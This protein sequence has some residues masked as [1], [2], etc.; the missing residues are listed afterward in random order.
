MTNHVLLDNVSHKDL[1]VNKIYRPGGPYDVNVARVFPVEFRQVQ[2]DYPLFFVK[3]KESGHFETVAL[4]GF[5]QGENLFLDKNGWDAAHIPLSIQRQPL[6]I[7]FQEQV[8]DGVPRRVPV[9]HIDL[10]HP[11]VSETEGEPLFLPHGGESPWL[12]QMSSVLHAIQQG[13]ETSQ[14][15]SELLVGL[16]LIESLTVKVEFVD[17]SKHSLTGL[18]TINEDK[19]AGLGAKALE[20]LHQKGHLFDVY[21]LLASLPNVGELIKR[22][23]RTLAG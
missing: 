23:N 22:K 9:V 3:N 5:D 14:S 15:F 20:V 19:L 4:L 10:D 18:Y 7:G 12:E 8:D 11:E 21:M 2:M 13:H 16:E 1:R 17:G 6:L